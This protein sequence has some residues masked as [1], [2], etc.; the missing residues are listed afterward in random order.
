MNNMNKVF[1]EGNLVKDPEI[2][3]TPSGTQ[4]TN[5]SIAVN[6]LYRKGDEGDR[7]KEVHYF[8]VEAWGR[9]AENVGRYT[10]KGKLVRVEGR[11][12][13]DRWEQDGQTRS[14]IKVVAELVQFM[15]QFKKAAE[16][17]AETPDSPEGDEL[18]D[19]DIPFM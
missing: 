7:V 12:K 1:L 8:D 19:E 4:V 9:L 11:L 16:Q 13:Q 3:T 18:R 15:P 5:F 14:R 6:R 10:Q 2:A 17:D